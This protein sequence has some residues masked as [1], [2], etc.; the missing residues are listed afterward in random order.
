MNSLFMK[1]HGF[2]VGRRRQAGKKGMTTHDPGLERMPLQPF[3]YLNH[4]PFENVRPEMGAALSMN[5]KTIIR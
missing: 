1:S 4:I 5:R 3:F 2:P